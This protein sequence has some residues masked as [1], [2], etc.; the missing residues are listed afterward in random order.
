[1]GRG[2]STRIHFPGMMSRS[3]GAFPFCI[4]FC[5]DDLRRSV[6]LA[7]GQPLKDTPPTTC[8]RSHDR[9][10]VRCRH[11]ARTRMPCVA[12]NGSASRAAGCSTSQEAGH[13][14]AHANSA[15][16]DDFLACMGR[17]VAAL[18]GPVAGQS[19]PVGVSISLLLAGG[20]KRCRE[21]LA[22]GYSRLL[23]PVPCPCG[24]CRRLRKRT[25]RSVSSK[26]S[27]VCASWLTVFV[28]RASDAISVQP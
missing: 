16:G 25:S 10:S 26:P 22:A 13:L 24:R 4:G 14:L 15:F 2:P 27:A 3:R 5:H 28:R 1:M 7:R 12:P 17:Q 18:L 8:A 20:R 23:F 9:D 11:P 21:F 6:H 19:D